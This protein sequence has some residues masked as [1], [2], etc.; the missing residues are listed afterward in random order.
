MRAR[1]GSAEGGQ[2]AHGG[3]L[4]ERE[5]ELAGLTAALGSARRGLGEV[6]YIESPAG[7]GRSRLLEV[8]AQQAR[9]ADMR[10]FSARGRELERGF[11]FG[12]AM[13]LFQNDWPW[14][15]AAGRER[16]GG[17]SAG[18][19]GGD[20][21]GNRRGGSP[22]AD[23]FMVTHG[24]FNLARKLG[25]EGES[26]AFLVDDLQHVDQPSLGF[27]AYLAARIEELPIALIVTAV[28]GD[29]GPERRALDALRDS[30]GDAVL[31]LDRLTMDGVAAVVRAQ[32]SQ[33]GPEVWQAC[34]EATGGIPF[35]L[36]E[37][38]READ[39]AGIGLDGGDADRIA[40]LVPDSVVND[41]KARLAA[42]PAEAA[43]L[44][45]AIAALGDG[46]SLRQA[47]LVAELA[48]PIASRCADALAAANVLRPGAPLL[49]AEPLIGRAVRISAS[50]LER[51]SMH[52]RAATIRSE[53]GAS[54]HEVASHLL[55]SP[56]S[57]DPQ[58]VEMLRSAA[59][60]AVA[61]GTPESAVR[62]L[63]RALRE[64]S[65]PVARAEV[66]EELRDAKLA[67]RP[68]AEAARSGVDPT[69]P[70]RITL[71]Q[72]ALQ[73]S[74]RGEPRAHVTS[75]VERAWGDGA[76]LGAGPEPGQLAASLV[77]ALL[78]VDE[79]ERGLQISDAAAL[80]AGDRGGDAEPDPRIWS[81]Y[82]QGRVAVAATQA[83]NVL[84]RR[85][86]TGEPP[87]IGLLGALT[88]C[89]LVLGEPAAADALLAGIILPEDG[90]QTDAPLLLEARAQLRLVQMRP[91]EALADALEAGRRSQSAIGAVHP[92]ILAWRST[93]ALA[94][95]ALGESAGAQTLAE[96]ELELAR[97]GELTRVM[98]RDLRVLGLVDR[99]S[100][101]LELLAEAVEL[102][103][104]YPTRLEYI[105]AL[106]DLGAAL[107]R[108]NQRAAAREPLRR[109]AELAGAADA[110][111][112]TLRA[113]D[114]L[115]ATG[116]RPRSTA[117][118]GLEALTPSERRVAD[119]AAEGRTTR[120]IASALFVT[121]KTVEFH[122]R[123]VYRKLDVPS[124][125]AELIRALH[126]ESAPPPPD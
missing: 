45:S 81:L 55:A 103:R 29:P 28:E 116:A 92:G 53:E 57:G 88:L 94:Q 40:E 19:R 122:L 90:G 126:A 34:A 72:M 109:A 74:I 20:S 49:F 39:R 110:S 42:L 87:D 67:A 102:G 15:D 118:S 105:R 11:P 70:Q 44:A 26:I 25:D 86:Q 16:R 84:E 8:A 106:V 69:P 76:L 14:G 37:L 33:A 3:D 80:S 22:P 89:L 51:A 13:A 12:L 99:S 47:A 32:L 98:M 46:V 111:A 35:L 43:T 1:R 83:R 115:V 41:V 10:V 17:D 85:A 96:E 82:H 125:R 68:L 60:G 113:R 54:P 79:L 75:L 9:N 58:A 62:L 124:S 59:R 63:V 27:L 91:A 31:R 101:G 108:A 23:P 2:N 66:F 114:E 123:H 71:A 56:P 52:L 48:V 117:F 36:C 78:F 30:A 65:E 18:H 24:L 4:V 73:S 112:L 120:Q 93:A 38:L 6:V 77:S 100:R 104:S 97:S 7:M 119:L 64:T 5:S 61:A 121:R 95:L 21:P 107:R 50:D